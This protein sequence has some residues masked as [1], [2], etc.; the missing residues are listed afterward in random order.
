MYR[1]YINND[2]Y[3][4]THCRQVTFIGHIY[5]YILTSLFID[6]PMARKK[7]VLM[8]TEIG[9]VESSFYRELSRDIGESCID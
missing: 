5:I 4:Y 3:I 8:G 7:K 2:I 6:S 9:S 1:I